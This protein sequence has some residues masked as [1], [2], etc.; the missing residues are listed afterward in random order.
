MYSFAGS[1]HNYCCIRDKKQF[2]KAI[3]YSFLGEKINDEKL[4]G[5]P[6]KWE[7][8]S[9]TLDD[10][11]DVGTDFPT[12][13]VWQS[14][15][16]AVQLNLCF[17]HETDNEERNS[18]KNAD[19]DKGYLNRD[20]HTNNT[21]NRDSSSN[22]TQ[23]EINIEPSDKGDGIAITEVTGEI[24]TKPQY[25]FQSFR[26]GFPDTN[27]SIF[28]SEAIRYTQRALLKDILNVDDK[29]RESYMYYDNRRSFNTLLEI[30]SSITEIH[31]TLLCDA[32]RPLPLKEFELMSALFNLNDAIRLLR[33]HK[34]FPV[35]IMYILCDDDEVDNSQKSPTRFRSA[36]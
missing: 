20:R 31:H 3:T 26:D 14:T 11:F 22:Q 34:E 25:A 1:V 15:L 16:D 6:W 4:E 35:K 13:E 7:N 24:Q 9:W 27:I 23:P 30:M 28:I 5:N 17:Q 18:R 29:F 32:L 12:T 19:S 33:H 36:D 10:E 21:N 2:A 8:E